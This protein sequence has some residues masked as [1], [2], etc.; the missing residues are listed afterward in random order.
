MNIKKP[1]VRSVV[2]EIERLQNKAAELYMKEIQAL[3]DKY[4]VSFATGQMSDLWQIQDTTKWNGF[5]HIDPELGED[6]VKNHPAA[7]A[8][9][10]LCKFADHHGI[11]PTNL[12][13]VNPRKKK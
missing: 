3:A 4:N 13:R 9:M 12:E 6:W 11:G 7:K 10:K 1:T 2:R 5:T 8:L